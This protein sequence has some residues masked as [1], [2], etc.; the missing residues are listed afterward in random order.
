[1][2]SLYIFKKADRRGGNLNLRHLFMICFIFLWLDSLLKIFFSITSK[3]LKVNKDIHKIPIFFSLLLQK[4]YVYKSVYYIRWE[5]G[6]VYLSWTF[7]DPVHLK[8]KG[9]SI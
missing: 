2:I 4:L 3:H 1:M 8:D 6:I 7:K 9:I 5:W